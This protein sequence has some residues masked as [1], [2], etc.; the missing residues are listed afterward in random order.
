MTFI[1]VIYDKG[2]NGPVNI[3]KKAIRNMSSQEIISSCFG[4][5]R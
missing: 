4:M 5:F 3:T 2:N 1:K